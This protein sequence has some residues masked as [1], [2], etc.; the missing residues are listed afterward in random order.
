M[1]KR[2][3]AAA[4]KEVSFLKLMGIIGPALLLATA[5][6]LGLNILNQPRAKL[7]Q[8][9]AEKHRKAE[10]FWKAAQME[11]LRANGTPGIG[12]A[13]KAEADAAAAYLQAVQKHCAKYGSEKLCSR[14]NL[15]GIRRQVEEAQKAA[16]PNPR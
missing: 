2:S 6:G 15:D 13:R 1:G 4:V 8:Q 16:N 12:A 3:K 10:V 14:P 9:D 11:T 7:H 5:I